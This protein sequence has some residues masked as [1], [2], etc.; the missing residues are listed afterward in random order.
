MKKLIEIHFERTNADLTPGNFRSIGSRVEIMPVSETIMYQ[1]EIS[2]G[3]ISKIR[4]IEPISSQVIKE[5]EDIFIFPAKHFIT[6]DIKKKKALVEIK[7]E[8]NNQLKKFEK[9]GKLLEA[10]RIKEEPIMTWR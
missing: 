5:E 3:K 7:K 4:K 9:E 2:D 6:E 10:E 1:V 8:L